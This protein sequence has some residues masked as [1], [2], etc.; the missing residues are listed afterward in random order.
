ML[1]LLDVAFRWRDI[2]EAGS[3]LGLSSDIASWARIQDIFD[4]LS[5]LSKEDIIAK[6]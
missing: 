4:Q 5:T 1:S 6:V 3:T 2:A